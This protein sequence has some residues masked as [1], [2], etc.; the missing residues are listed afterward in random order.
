MKKA[1][2][3][4]SIGALAGIIDVIP[5]IVMDLT[6]DA[7]LAAFSM[8][9]IVGLFISV[10]DVKLNSFAKGI[11][12]AYLVLFPSAILIGWKEPQSLI[13]IVVM[14]TILGGLSG[15]FIDLV[16]KRKKL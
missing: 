6:W 1:F 3:G 2:I 4:L 9:V 12:T 7:N 8:W 16:I 14:T 5:M 10:V 15:F 13:P 11:L